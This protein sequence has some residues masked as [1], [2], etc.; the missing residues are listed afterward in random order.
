MS[1]L[2]SSSWA[3]TAAGVGSV[4]VWP[5]NWFSLF[6]VPSTM[7]PAKNSEHTSKLLLAVAVFVA[8]SF[9]THTLSLCALFTV[10]R[11]RFSDYYYHFFFSLLSTSVARPTNAG[12]DWVRGQSEW[13]TQAQAQ[14]RH[15]KWKMN[16]LN[17]KH[18]SV[19]CIYETSHERHSAPV[20]ASE[21]L[22]A[23]MQWIHF[24]FCPFVRYTHT[25]TVVLVAR[26]EHENS[27]K[28]WKAH[29]NENT[30]FHAWFV[31]VF[32][33]CQVRKVCIENVSFL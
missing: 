33:R 18:N 15:G 27:P 14:T 2:S 25:H 5:K 21:Y 1:M 7:E 13:H 29:R 31:W 26:H 6:S 30:Y 19:G 23:F 20:C 12:T 9:N 11:L 3:A 17:G 10:S 24:D 4:L 16:Y 8:S 32:K 28:M 22:C